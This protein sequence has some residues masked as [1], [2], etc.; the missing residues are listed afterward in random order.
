[1]FDWLS[2]SNVWWYLTGVSIVTFLISII[3]LPVLAA[4][5]PVDYFEREV[6]PPSRFAALHPVLRIFLVI[7]KN[8]F[9]GLLFLAGVA[10]LIL[11]GNGILAIAIAL[12]MMD[13]PG[14]Y[15]IERWMIMRAPVRKCIG[16][17]RQKAGRPQLAIP[18]DLMQRPKPRTAPLIRQR[19]TS[20]AS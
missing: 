11:P 15:K 19:A 8:T 3:L 17:V 5:I 13:L 4:R 1:M 12:L 10:M 2:N 20:P 18:D 14:K 16:W 7:L 9:A 6:R